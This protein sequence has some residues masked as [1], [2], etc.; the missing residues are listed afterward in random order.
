MVT[1]QHA[2][3][4]KGKQPPASGKAEGQHRT[5][6]YI[7]HTTEGGVTLAAA[8]KKPVVVLTQSGVT[9]NGAAQ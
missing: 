5:V 4:A 1:K 2:G 3:Q 7:Q 6:G 9:P 8:G